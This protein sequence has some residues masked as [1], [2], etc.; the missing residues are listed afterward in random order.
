MKR[1]KQ[2]WDQM[3]NIIEI[4]SNDKTKQVNYKYHYEYHAHENE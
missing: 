2:T 4:D 1:G 3:K